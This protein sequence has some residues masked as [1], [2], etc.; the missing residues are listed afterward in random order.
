LLDGRQFETDGRLT[1]IARHVEGRWQIVHDHAS[2]P[3]PEKPWE[4]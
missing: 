3:L 4:P 1:A 2:I